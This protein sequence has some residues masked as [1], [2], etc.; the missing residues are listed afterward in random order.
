MK[1]DP[2]ALMR[3]PFADWIILSALALAALAATAGVSEFVSRQ[4]F[5][6]ETPHGSIECEVRNDSPAGARAKPDSSCWEKLAE[7]TLAEYKFNHCGDREFVE[8]RSAHPGVFRI[9]MTGSSVAVGRYLPVQKTIAEFL[10][11]AI[12]KRIPEPVEVYNASMMQGSLESVGLRFGDILAD[13][14]DMVLWV[15]TP[16]DVEEARYVTYHDPTSQLQADAGGALSVKRAWYLIKRAY[17]NRSI[18]DLARSHFDRTRTALALRHLLYQ[19]RGIYVRSSLMQSDTDAGYLKRHPS[20][21]WRQ[22]IEE[23]GAQFAENR[24]RAKAAG[25]PLVIVSIPSR[26]QAALLATSE[27]HDDIDPYGFDRSLQSIVAAQGE[28]Y[29]EILPALRGVPEPERLYYPVDG[30]P[31]ERGTFLIARALADRISVEIQNQSKATLT[32]PVTK[33]PGGNRPLGTIRRPNGLATSS[34]HHGEGE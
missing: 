25:V 27:E 31:N 9:V 3:L 34:V 17:V 23:F 8:C 2:R 13:K 12:E 7:G 5:S 22:R 11:S 29:V 18:A 28:V 20:E 14:P 6:E 19:S 30:H 21:I 26:E 33:D 1:D 4:I 16:H 24:A 15:V 10:S 32:D